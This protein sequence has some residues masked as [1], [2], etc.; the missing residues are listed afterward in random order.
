MVAE[1]TVKHRVENGKACVYASDL[2]V[3]LSEVYGSDEWV[4]T[5]DINQHFNG[6]NPPSPRP[7]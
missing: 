6:I 7:E 5:K 4:Y 2:G 3:L 1:L